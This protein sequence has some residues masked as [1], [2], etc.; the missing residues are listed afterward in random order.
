MADLV[1]VEG[2]LDGGKP[3]WDLDMGTLNKRLAVVQQGF[4]KRVGDA[5]ATSANKKASSAGSTTKTSADPVRTAP[6][7]LSLKLS[8]VKAASGSPTI[9]DAES[10]VEIL[11]R[12]KKRPGSKTKNDEPANKKA[13]IIKEESD[14]DRK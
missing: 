2:V 8:S 1:G 4:E 10:D 11:T 5:A 9:S 14:D 12:P 6:K 13:R 7:A 3:R